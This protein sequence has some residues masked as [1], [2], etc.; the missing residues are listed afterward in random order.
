MGQ[1]IGIDLGTTNSVGAIVL[2]AGK[3]DVIPTQERYRLTPSVVVRDHRD[4]T[5]LVGHHAINRA[6]ADPVNAIFSIKRL[7]GRRY[8]DPEVER[9]RQHV[10]YRVLRPDENRDQA[11]V[12]LG[13]KSYSPI[14]I[15][16]LILAKIKADAEAAFS[17]SVT[18][19]VITVPA[20]FDDNQREATRQAG[21]LA[22]FKVKRIIDEPT[23]AAYAFGLTLDRNSAK[24]IIVY[25]LGGGTFDI[26]IISISEGIPLVEHIEGDNWLGGDR[27]DAMIMDYVISQMER[28]QPGIGPQLRADAEFLWRVRRAAEE[29]KKQLGASPTADIVLYGM[30]KGKVDVDVQVQR[31]DFESW[32][33]KDIEGSV[34]LMETAMAGP[35][36]TPEDIDNVLLVGGSTALPMVRRLLAAKFGEEK[37][38]AYVD[39]MECVALGA[40]I[41]ASRTEK[42]VCPRKECQSENEPDAKTCAGPKC[43]ADI[44]DLE[45]QVKCPHCGGL[46]P[47]GEVVCP[48][49]NKPLVVEPEGVTAKPYGIE[50][51]GGKFHII[52]PKSTRYPTSEPI[53][54][55]FRTVA[56]GQE[57]IIIPVY[58]GFEE[59]ASRNELQAE[60]VLPERGPIAEDQRVP[61]GTPL[62]IG[63]KID[64]NGTLEIVVKGKGPLA[65]LQFGQVLRPW[66]A[67]PRPAGSTA[68]TGPAS[69]ACPRCNHQNR[70]GADVCEQCG[71]VIGGAGAG[72]GGAAEPEW[73]RELN[74]WV[75][76]A[77]VAIHEYAWTTQESH[78]SQLRSLA[79]RGRRALDMNDEAT[80]RRTAEELKRTVETACGH[81]LDLVE[82]E[83][84]Y[85]ARM[86][87]LDLSQ[88]LGNLLGEYKQ[89]V[90]RGEEQSG[91]AMVSLRNRIGELVQQIIGGL[92]DENKVECTKCHQMRPRPTPSR[93]RC[94][95]KLKDGS[96]C[97]FDPTRVG[98]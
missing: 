27:F 73:K 38:K 39:P 93:P 24:T 31:S 21:N 26:S 1:S 33:R 44:S 71:E 45:A 56:D 14:E 98:L 64:K 51:E 30:L 94:P 87:R 83:L 49:V 8:T 81:F 10:S 46:H 55:E 12:Q 77:Q 86:G 97:G 72:A 74:F 19:A 18:H 65:W 85:R 54:Q 23:A 17:E 2:G 78:L 32:I 48:E 5:I 69:A 52:V 60:I 47:K 66:E 62:D 43:G 88:Q 79:E 16:A 91:S 76:F 42:K 37:I 29:A 20:Y 70:H 92:G 96:V 95:N 4:G 9:V 58:Q 89:R 22:G 50:I 25:D 53:F 40:A 6:Q 28:K 7:M 15:S 82:A 59:V 13:E 90:R 68:E 36:L 11:Y 41:L 63:F 34:A 84:V 67:G 3:P 80:G 35:G 57:R 75:N 61:K